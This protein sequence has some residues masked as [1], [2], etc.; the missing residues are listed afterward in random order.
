MGQ[1]M[2]MAAPLARRETIRESIVR[3]LAECGL[4]PE[5]MDEL[6]IPQLAVIRAQKLRNDGKAA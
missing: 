4:G 2:V 3:I 1:K 6:S 5:A